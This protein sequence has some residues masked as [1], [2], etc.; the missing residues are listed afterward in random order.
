MDSDDEDEDGGNAPIIPRPFTTALKYLPQLRS[1]SIENFSR[2]SDKKFN[3]AAALPNLKQVSTGPWWEA[4]E[5]VPEEDNVLDVL[6]TVDWEAEARWVDSLKTI[7]QYLPEARRIHLAAATQ[8]EIDPPALTQGPCTLASDYSAEVSLSLCY[9][10]SSLTFPTCRIASPSL[11][12]CSRS[13]TTSLTTPSWPPSSQ[14]SPT[15]P[16]SIRLSSRS[17]WTMAAPRKLCR[18]C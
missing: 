2:F 17:V 11:S 1:L 7:S 8:D 5:W 10:A 13:P 14:R 6:Y 16:P 9:Y 15:P 4:D 18:G 3:L 12:R